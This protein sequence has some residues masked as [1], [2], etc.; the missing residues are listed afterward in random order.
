M[1][2][3]REGGSQGGREEEMKGGR[4]GRLCKKGNLICCC[5]GMARWEGE[6]ERGEE[7]K[8]ANWQQCKGLEERQVEK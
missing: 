3:A 1:H 8:E 2:G 6:I 4:E 7:G 5:C